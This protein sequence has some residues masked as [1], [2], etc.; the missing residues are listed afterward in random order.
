MEQKYDMPIINESKSIILD[1]FF[2][3]Y[4]L[5]LKH[6]ITNIM[7]HKNKLYQ[8][9]QN[10]IM[11]KIINILQLDKENSILLY[12]LDNDESKKQK[13]MD[14]I[15]DI[16]KYFTYDCIPGVRNP[17]QTKRAYLS[18]IRQITKLG[19]AMKSYDHRI[20]EKAKEPI[21]TIKYI[22]S[23]KNT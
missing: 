9:E 17:E 1:S 5:K 6:L 18:I 23:K 4:Y 8:K 2:L 22:F 13:I 14:L 20:S 11:N 16:R 10:D 7:R 12:D 3:L 21:R 19:Y 15:P